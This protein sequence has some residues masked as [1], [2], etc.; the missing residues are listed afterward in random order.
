MTY[1]HKKYQSA[2]LKR[3]R[4]SLHRFIIGFLF[5]L[6]LGGLLGAYL[7]YAV[8]FKPNVWTPGE[9]DISIYINSNSD[10]DNVKNQLYTQGLIIHRK[11]FEWLAE[12]KN[13]ID[14]VKGGRYIISHGM[15]NDELINLLR[16]GRQ[17]P[18][19]L[20][21][22]NIRDIHQLAG[23]VAQQIEADSA[24][25]VLLLSDSLFIGH[26]GFNQY[27]IPA[28]FI[29]NTYELYWT[30]DADGF[31]SRMFQEYRNFWSQE[32]QAKAKTA[33]LNEL[34]VSILASIVDRETIMDEEKPTIAGVYINRLRSGWRLQADPTL[35]FAAGDF[36]IRR[37]LDVHKTIESPYN[38]YKY[39]G[40]PPG[41]ITIPSIAS[42]DAVLNYEN[43]RYY[44]F[45]ARDDL[46]GYHAFARTNAEHERNARR[47]R[48]ALDRAN[49]KK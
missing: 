8:I 10:F 44:F 11:N 40:L 43:H 25:I 5:I 23:R 24:S 34:E 6:I 4:S 46:S 3:K 37:V 28:L 32:R 19:K 14:N 20:T 12:K 26:L 2:R 30:T 45:C 48:Q 13:Y 47:Y 33:G 21:F 31:V 16:S 22:N 27:T 29:P 15:S 35:V 1:Y 39:S 42:I 38:T 17:S 36:E 9:A 18:I 7:L 49:I 41:P